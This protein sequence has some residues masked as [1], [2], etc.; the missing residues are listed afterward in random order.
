MRKR[1]NEVI[2]KSIKVLLLIVVC[3]VFGFETFMS[4]S[5]LRSYSNEI[6]IALLG[7]FLFSAYTTVAM[8]RELVL[9]IQRKKK[10]D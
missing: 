1:T 2:D 8:F 10:H 4:F 5:H 7:A 3:I 9:A 6:F